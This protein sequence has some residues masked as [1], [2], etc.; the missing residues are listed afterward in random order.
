VDWAA[1]WVRS[2]GSRIAAGESVIIRGKLIACYRRDHGRLSLGKNDRLFDDRDSQPDNM[3]NKAS[4][5]FMEYSLI[6]VMKKKL[7]SMQ[8][9]LVLNQ[10]Q[11]QLRNR[12]ADLSSSPK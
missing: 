6:Q 10:T 3:M 11:V 5:H 12:I 4:E 8:V 1:S 2:D 9:V 7:R